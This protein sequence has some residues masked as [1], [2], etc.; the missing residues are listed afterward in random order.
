MNEL[1]R[2]LVEEAVEDYEEGRLTRREA[3]KAIAGITGAALAAQMLEARAQ[4]APAGADDSCALEADVSRANVGECAIS[5]M[6]N[7][8][9]EK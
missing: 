9:D 4:A 3:L 5:N 8:I 7:T 1:Q 6:P 2:Y